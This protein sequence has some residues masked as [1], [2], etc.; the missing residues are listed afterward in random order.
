[1]GGS[2]GERYITH[3]ISTGGIVLVGVKKRFPADTDLA[4]DITFLKDKKLDGDL[5]NLLQLY[6]Y[7]VDGE[8]T[9]MKTSFLTQEQIAE[10]L[11]N[12]SSVRT[13]RN[14]LKYLIEKGY[15]I[16]QKDRYILPRIEN[17]YIMI[18]KSASQFIF[19]SMKPHI[20]KMY[21]YLGQRYKY[22]D[23]YVFTQEEVAKHLGI[24]LTGNADA[25]SKIKNGLLLLRNCGLVTFAQFY[26][27]KVPKYRLLHWSSEY[28]DNCCYIDEEKKG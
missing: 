28:I 2:G 7:P 19:D 6:S 26:D 15:V 23:G 13:V 11:S 3:V 18:D 9:V 17:V 4:K 22:K 16:E 8:T 14:H 5:Y 10:K 27:G 25:R 12:G 21:I 24:N 1:M 20:L